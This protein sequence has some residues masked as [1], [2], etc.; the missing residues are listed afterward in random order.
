MLKWVVRFTTSYLLNPSIIYFRNEPIKPLGT[1]IWN[2]YIETYTSDHT[3]QSLVGRMRRNVIPNLDFY[4]KKMKTHEKV[5]LYR[6]FGQRLNNQKRTV[7]VLQ[8]V[9]LEN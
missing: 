9:Y 4:L 3:V 2:N 6:I 5:A 7:F 1:S 8:N